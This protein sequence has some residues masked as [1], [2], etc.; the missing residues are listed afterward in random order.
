MGAD[1]ELA[2][3]WQPT[4][5]ELIDRVA[6]AVEVWGVVLEP[7]VYVS[8][9]TTPI[10]RVVDEPHFDDDRFDPDHGVG[11]A[12]IVASHLGPRVAMGEL[13]CAPPVA[14]L[15]IALADGAVPDPDDS[16]SWWQG[17]ADQVV[18]ITRFGQLHRGPRLANLVGVADGP[19][20]DSRSLLVLRAGTVPA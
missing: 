18:L 11:L 5:E 15:P 12:A 16:T 19:G 4:V 13:T 3:W 20:T 17:P 2:R 9:S 8:V 14:G 6:L 10:D 1:P 7:P